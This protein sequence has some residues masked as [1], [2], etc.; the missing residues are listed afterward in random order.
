MK[1]TSMTQIYNPC[2]V[3][4]F[5]EELME[6]Q[7][8]SGCLNSGCFSLSDMG[9]VL[10]TKVQNFKIHDEMLSSTLSAC[11]CKE[12]LSETVAA[13]RNPNL[14]RFHLVFSVICCYFV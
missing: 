1:T 14:S 7:K 3:Q 12:Y 5:C 4:H 9:E 11:F 13:Q 8:M 10:G 6:N 2:V